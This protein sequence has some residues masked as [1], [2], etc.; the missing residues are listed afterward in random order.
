MDALYEVLVHLKRSYWP[1]GWDS[2]YTQGG[3]SFASYGG[4]DAAARAAVEGMQSA[5]MEAISRTAAHRLSRGIWTS[6]GAGDLRRAK[7]AAC[8]KTTTSSVSSFWRHSNSEPPTLGFPNLLVT[9][10]FMMGF[11]SRELLYC[12]ARRDAAVLLIHSGEFAQGRA[13]LKAYLASAESREA[14]SETRILVDR[15]MDKVDD[16]LGPRTASSSPKP[17][18]SVSSVLRKGRPEEKTADLLDLPW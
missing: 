4:F 18:I 2:S 9:V 5:E 12:L 14:P 3:E 7:A 15:L 10:P 6:P 17:V 8:F 1:F 13:E 16:M 11:I